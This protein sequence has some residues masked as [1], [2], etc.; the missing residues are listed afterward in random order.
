MMQ[1]VALT[2]DGATLTGEIF[3]PGASGKQPGVL[4][5]HSGLGL[6]AHERQVAADLAARGYAALAVDM[7]GGTLDGSPEV[8]GA[9]FAQLIANPA[10]VRSRVGVWFDCMT[11]L[12]G[13][14]AGRIAAIGYCFGGMCVLELARSGADVK[15]AISFHGL[16]T[17]VVPATPGSIRGQVAAW[18]GGKD[19]YAPSE[20]IDAFRAEMAAA[21]ASCQITVFS[22]VQ[23]SFTDPAAD[24]LNR[25]GIAYDALADRVS[26]AGTVA[27]LE[28]V[29]GRCA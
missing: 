8:A 12:P 25:P 17:T 7:F 6:G 9:Y 19:P 21:Q 2:H 14:D 18:C 10:L 5:F 11:A 1:P 26:W 16:L 15:A 22:D 27:L 29:L 3:A 28:S 24:G 20:Q 13:I 23:H 4:V